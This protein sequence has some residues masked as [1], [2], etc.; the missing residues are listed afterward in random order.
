M[1]TYMPL[2]Y[3]PTISATSKA[4]EGTTEEINMSEFSASSLYDLL[5]FTPV[6]SAISLVLVLLPITHV[7]TSAPFPIK[8]AEM[9]D[10]T[11]PNPKNPTFIK[12][13]HL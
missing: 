6:F 4:F 5:N 7:N 8:P 12:Q 13:P 10:A 11:S 3:F 1:S 2:E 9:I